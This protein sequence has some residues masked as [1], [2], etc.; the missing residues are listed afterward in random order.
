MPLY[1]AFFLPS[2]EPNF[3]KGLI[4]NTVGLPDTYKLLKA[5]HFSF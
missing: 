3:N 1:G 2:D 5:A 4:F